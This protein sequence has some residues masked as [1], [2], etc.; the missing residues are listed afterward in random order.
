MDIE[1]RE[2]KSKTKNT[3]KQ[4]MRGWKTPSTKR[5]SILCEDRVEWDKE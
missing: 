5:F 2:S 3:K 4:K 1:P